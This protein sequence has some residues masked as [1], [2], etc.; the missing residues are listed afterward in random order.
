VG[1]RGRGA[2]AGG[3]EGACGCST[4]IGP[5]CSLVQSCCSVRK[6]RTAA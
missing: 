5:G 3:I 2:A 1:E 4:G 6:K